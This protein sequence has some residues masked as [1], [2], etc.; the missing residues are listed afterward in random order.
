MAANTVVW[1][2]NVQDVSALWSGTFNTGLWFYCGIYL[3][4]IKIQYIYDISIWNE[5]VK[6]VAHLEAQYK[7]QEER[8]YGKSFMHQTFLQKKLLHLKK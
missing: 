5:H 6:S 3:K 4:T 1:E 7:T 8:G 2:N